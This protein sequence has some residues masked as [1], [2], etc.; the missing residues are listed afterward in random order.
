MPYLTIRKEVSS[1]ELTL[2]L[3]G[4]ALEYA[5]IMSD[6]DILDDFV[7][8]MGDYFE[9]KYPSIEEVSDY[10]LSNAN[11]YIILNRPIYTFEDKAEIEVHLI[12]NHV[13]Y[14]EEKLAKVDVDNYS[15]IAELK[16]DILPW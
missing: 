10:I 12:K 16:E 5:D 2:E 9:G 8:D 4:K 3:E 1:F 13:P 6:Y 7:Q 14:S 15:N 11:E